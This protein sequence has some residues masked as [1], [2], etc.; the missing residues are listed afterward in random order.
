MK[1]ISARTIPV[2]W[3]QITD[4]RDSPLTDMATLGRCEIGHVSLLGM[5][6]WGTSKSA[7]LRW[8]SGRKQGNHIK[9]DR[10]SH[11]VHP[12]ILHT[13]TLD[14]WVVGNFCS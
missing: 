4:N 11:F 2:L 8:G 13:S 3:N 12:K 5:Q 1:I 10:S 7:I 9:I 6:R 14:P